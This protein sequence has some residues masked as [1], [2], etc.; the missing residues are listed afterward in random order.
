V[1]IADDL[2]ERAVPTAQGG[3]QW[4]PATVRKVVATYDKGD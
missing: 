3:K 2:N 4:Y 1:A